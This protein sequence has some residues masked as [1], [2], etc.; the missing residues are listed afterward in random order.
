L[1]RIKLETP[2]NLEISIYPSFIS[3]LFKVYGNRLLKIYGVGKNCKIIVED[4]NTIVYSEECENYVNEWLGLWF[5]PYDF[6]AKVKRSKRHIVERILEVYVG[7]KLMVSPWDRDFIFIATFLSRRANYHVSVIKWMHKILDLV[8]EDIELTPLHDLT[9][10][11]GRSYQLKQL[12]EIIPDYLKLRKITYEDPWAERLNL[13]KLKYV[14]PKVTDA[15]L[16]FTGKGSIYTPSDVHYQRFTRYL[17]LID[18]DKYV[19][20]SKQHCILNNAYCLNCSLSNEC[21]TGLSVRIYDVLSGWLQTVGYVHDKLYC[22][23]NRCRECPL[24]NICVK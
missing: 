12:M 3:F 24:K 20:P 23:R 10:S 8:N 4:E 11:V 16:L 22:S 2:I 17:G 1:K 14:G 13:M 6:L 7:L 15:Y 21:L 9:E 5:N 18:K 19:I